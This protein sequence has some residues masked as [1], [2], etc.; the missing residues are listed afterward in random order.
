M[1]VLKLLRF[2]WDRCLAV[3]LG[4]AG[5]AAIFLGWLGVSDA[6]LPSEQIPYVVSGGLGGLFLLGIGATLWISA[7]LRDEWRA[8]DRLQERLPQDDQPAEVLLADPADVSNGVRATSSPV[9]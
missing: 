6:V 2:Q 8:L 9:G 7:D 4:L 3:A 5:A 1:D